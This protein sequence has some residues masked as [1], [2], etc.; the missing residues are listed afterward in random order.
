L[1]LHVPEGSSSSTKGLR[2]ETGGPT[3]R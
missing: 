2:P 1:T 3:A